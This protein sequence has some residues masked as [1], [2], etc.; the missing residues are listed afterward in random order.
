MSP[1]GGSQGDETPRKP[2]KTAHDLKAAHHLASGAL[3]GFTS[4]ICLQPLDL[5]KTRLQ[6]SYD[7]VGGDSR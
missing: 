5:L 3:S 4:A 1:S 2:L 7:G 6:Q